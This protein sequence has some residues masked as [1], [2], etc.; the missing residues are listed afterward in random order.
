MANNYSI[1]D[2]VIPTKSEFQLNPFVYRITGISGS[3]RNMYYEIT[4][5]DYMKLEN[6]IV[7]GHTQTYSD[8]E[9]K[10]VRKPSWWDD[11]IVS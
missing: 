7:P 10:E 4:K 6:S 5:Y 3:G 8:N 1:G 2:F 11:S 9:F